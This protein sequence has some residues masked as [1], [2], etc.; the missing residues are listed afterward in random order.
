[1][2]AY[3]LLNVVNIVNW[4]AETIKPSAQVCTNSQQITTNELDYGAANAAPQ[5]K[6]RYN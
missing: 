4:L 6:L 5:G 2:L 3:A 1:M